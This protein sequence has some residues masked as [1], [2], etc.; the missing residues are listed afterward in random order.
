[1]LDKITCMGFFLAALR[2]MVWAA[3]ICIQQSACTGN[4]LYSRSVSFLDI[5]PFQFILFSMGHTVLQHCT[6][7][8]AVAL[9]DFSS[10]P[11]AKCFCSALYSRDS[12]SG[13]GSG[14]YSWIAAVRFF[15]G[16][17]SFRR[18]ALWNAQALS[19]QGESLNC[20]II[21]TSRSFV[22]L[23]NRFRSSSDCRTP[24]W[25]FFFTAEADIAGHNA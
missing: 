17:A 3:Y 4:V 1:M 7:K 21:S 8:S 2:S 5:T 22:L 24:A 20:P 19:I 9:R 6:R 14:S 13:F 11:C 16:D 23:G 25:G 12:F 18:T 15:L 10:N